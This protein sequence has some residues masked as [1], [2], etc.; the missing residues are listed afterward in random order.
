MLQIALT[1][2]IRGNL[3]GNCVAIKQANIIIMKNKKIFLLSWLSALCQNTKY[4]R[5]KGTDPTLAYN[6][7]ESIDFTP[8]V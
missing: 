5:C 7:Q 4:L 1:A 6:A 8:Y 2:S 3:G